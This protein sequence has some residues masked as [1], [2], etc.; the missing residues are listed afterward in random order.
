MN[1][2]VSP[3]QSTA[4]SEHKVEDSGYDNVYLKTIGLC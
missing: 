1:I 4:A 2:H 3:S